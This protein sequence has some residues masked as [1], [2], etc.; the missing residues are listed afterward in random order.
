[1]RRRDVAAQLQHHERAVVVR[2]E[3]RLEALDVGVRRDGRGQHRGSE[4][5]DVRLQLLDVG[6]G[7]LVPRPI[8]AHDEELGALGGTAEVLVDDLLGLD[9]LRVVLERHVVREHV[10]ERRRAQVA[11]RDDHEQPGPDRPPRVAARDLRQRLRV[12]LHL[13]LLAG[14]RV[15]WS[16]FDEAGAR[17]L[18]GRGGTGAPQARR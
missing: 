14:G 6:S 3:H 4:P 10:A 13:V 11:H 5:L 7:A 18:A 16:S 17:V 12:E 1:M 9:R 8:G 2:E 15:M